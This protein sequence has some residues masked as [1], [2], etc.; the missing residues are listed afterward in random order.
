M[1]RSIL[2]PLSF[3]TIKHPTGHPKFI[4]FWLPAF[5]GLISTALVS[6]L[7]DSANVFGPSGMIDKTLGFLQSLPGFYI[8]ALAA[9][10]TFNNI[11]ML[12]LMPGEPPTMTVVHN[13]GHEVVKLT[14]RRFLS[15]MFA[16][17]T[18]VSIFLTIISIAALTVGM[19]LKEILTNTS[20][21]LPAAM[22]KLHLPSSVDLACLV[23]PLRFVGLFLYLGLIC[24]MLLITL[25]GLFY[26]GERVHTP[27]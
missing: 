8:A 13:G 20:L 25:W 18:T 4:N 11:D 19:P 22:T 15:A 10:A 17:L 24:Q 16:Y 26:L 12:K 21:S 7:P 6:M 3:L 9:I 27:D 14:R 2:G 23:S 1:I 5:L